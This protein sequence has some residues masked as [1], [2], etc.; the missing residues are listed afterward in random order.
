MSELVSAVIPTYRR[1]GALDRSLGSVLRQTWRPLELVVVDDGSG[2]NTPEVLQA[3][4]DKA[5]AAGVEY[6]WHTKENGGPGAARNFGMERASGELFAF[7]DDDDRW[8]PQKIETQVAHMRM[9][10]ESGVSFTRY[11]HSGKEGQPKPRMENIRDGWVFDSLCSGQTR[12]H[13]QTLMIRREVFARVGGFASH[14]NFE[15]FEFCLRASL[16]FPFTAVA[17]A[18]TVIETVESSVSREAGLEGDLER[19]HLKLEVLRAFRQRHGAHERF[20]EP[21]MKQ[22]FAR[23]YDEHIKHLI[24]LGRVDEARAAWGRALDECGEQPQ[25]AALKSKLTRAKVAGWFGRK[26]RKP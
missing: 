1:P 24:W 15:D 26:L 13:L 17:E 5:K 20:H 8:Y 14:R 25:L 7:L 18:L 16:D 9:H 21:A 2:D 6:Q 12:A 4:A 11:V 10:P 22:A 19:D 23:I 3:W